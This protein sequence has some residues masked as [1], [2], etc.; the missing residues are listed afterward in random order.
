[1]LLLHLASFENLAAQS[2]DEKIEEYIRRLALKDELAFSELYNL[3]KDSVYGFALSILKNTHDAE[4]V[5]HDCYINVYR[6][7]ESYRPDGKP[8]AWMLTITKN[9]CFGKMRKNKNREDIPQED[10]E[11]YL[12]SKDEISTEDKLVLHACM[13]ILSDEER[14]IVVLHAVSGFK[15]REIASILDMGIS[16]VLSKYNRAVKKLKNQLEKESGTYDK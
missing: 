3:T 1:M 11:K 12:D 6:G 8:L 9:L 2:E 15:H 5:M 10:W 16:T 4:D 14:E 7:A 13:E